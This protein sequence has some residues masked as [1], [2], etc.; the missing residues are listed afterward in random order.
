MPPPPPLKGIR[1]ADL[2]RLLPGAFATLMLAELGADVIKIEDPRGG[3]PMRQLPPM[4]NGRGIY[5]YLL[6]RG[7]RSV[8]LDLKDPERVR[9]LHA[10]VDTAD[11]VVESFRPATARRLG[12]SGEQLR[13]RSPRLIHCAITGYGQS[14]PYAER[15]GHDLNYVSISGMLSADRPHLEKSGD[16]P[17]MFIA[18]VGGGAMTSVIGILAALFGR[19]RH[20]EGDSIDI[21]MHDAALYWVMLP[22]ARDLIEGGEQATG[23]LPTFG[24]HA[25]YNVYKTRDGRAIALG[26]L[27]EKFWAAFCEAIDRPDLIARHATEEGDQASLLAEV[28]ALFTERTRDEWMA[29]LTS[30]DVCATPVNT[31]KEALADPHVLARGTVRDHGTHRSIRAPFLRELP[32]LG[33][34]PEV[35][36]HT[37]EVLGSLS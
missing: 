1:V 3:D 29:L 37:D 5:D 12:V 35:G 23:E 33:P 7:K 14:G 9:Q 8:A 27:E 24:K 17:R 25:S 34:P 19:E 26:A 32:N 6:N 21:S 10:L 28:R 22:G 31:P 2:S 4:L 11:V 30:H 13:T 18:D 16:L 20:G 36:Q 15:P